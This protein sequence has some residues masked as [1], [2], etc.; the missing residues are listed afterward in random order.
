[1]IWNSELS[2]FGDLNRQ[3]MVSTN[4]RSEEVMFVLGVM[5]EKGGVWGGTHKSWQ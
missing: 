4:D 2:T 5:D 3:S 1:M